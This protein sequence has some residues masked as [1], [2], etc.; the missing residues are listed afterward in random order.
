ML[1]IP[2][3]A[4]LLP[5]LIPVR[6]ARVS[7]KKSESGEKIRKEIELRFRRHKANPVMQQLRALAEKHLLGDKAR[8]T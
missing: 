1:T 4:S 2:V 3:P 5:D 6:I 8:R 7:P